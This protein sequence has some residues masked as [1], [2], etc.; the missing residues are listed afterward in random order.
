MKLAVISHI[1]GNITALDAVLDDRKQQGIDL[2]VNPGDIL[3]GRDESAYRLDC[4][5]ANRVYGITR[6]G[7]NP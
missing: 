2:I 4:A 3:S 6:R 1:H 5:M 7:V